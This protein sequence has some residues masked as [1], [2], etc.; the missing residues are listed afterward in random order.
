MLSR[1]FEMIYESYCKAVSEAQENEA[2]HLGGLSRFLT[3]KKSEA[4]TLLP[5]FDAELEAE[6]RQFYL[7][8]PDSAEVLELSEWMLNKVDENCGKP[9]LKYSLMAVLRHLQPLLSC[10]N[11]EDAAFLTKKFETVLPRREQFP[12]HKELISSL[13]S[14]SQK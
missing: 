13:K 1:N 10:L 3:G 2:R 5:S 12:I 7:Q 8:Q 11:R 4:D 6:L 9:Q 14:Q